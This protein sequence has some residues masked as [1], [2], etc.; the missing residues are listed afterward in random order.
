V[1]FPQD[2]RNCTTCH[3]N[4]PNADNWKNNPSRAACGSCHDQIDWTTGKSNIASQPDHGGGPQADDKNCKMCHQPD[5]GQEFDASIVGAH[6]IP[7]KSKQLKGVNLSLIAASVS[8][9]QKPS[10][11]FSV[12]DNSGAAIDP[13]TLD[14]VQFIIGYPTAD[15]ANNA[16]GQAEY[17]NRILAA[18]QTPFVRTGVLTSLGSGAYRYTFANPVNVSWKTGSVA[19]G[20][21]GYKNTTIKGNFGKDTVVRETSLNPV[22]YVSLDGTAS[23]ARRVVVD[24]N[25]CNSCH[26]DLG[27]PAGLAVHGGSRRNTQLCVICHNANQTDEVNRT[28]A[29]MPPESVQ[30]KYMIHSLHMGQDRAVPTTFSSTSTTGVAY[31]TSGAQKDCLKCHLPGTYSLPLPPGALPMTI[32]QAGKVVK[33]VQPITAVCLGCHAGQTEFDAHAATYTTPDE[34]EQCVNCHGVGKPMDVV[35]VHAN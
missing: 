14:A 25:K 24:R 23:A 4:A 13:N 2:V 16:Q 29:N 11:D 8:A 22:I 32:T 28:A 9:G 10:V 35:T 7:A 6:T 5:S 31:P 17:A 15:Y 1:G 26:L 19:I 12:K 18:T 3:S 30:F 33:V 27:S 20:M 34:G 21:V